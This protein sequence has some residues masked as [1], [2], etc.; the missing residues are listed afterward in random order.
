[1]REVRDVRPVSTAMIQKIC[2]K[3]G[4]G[5]GATHRE[6]DACMMIA[7]EPDYLDRL[8]DE[9]AGRVFAVFIMTSPTL[10]PKQHTAAAFAA[11]DAMIE[12]HKSR[13]PQW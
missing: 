6:C 10:N 1:M 4:R 2:S 3:C 11:A 12:E 7:V 9:Y 13:Y 5:K 8:R